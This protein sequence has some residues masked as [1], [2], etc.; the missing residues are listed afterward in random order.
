MSTP[1]ITVIGSA[2]SG[3]KGAAAMLESAVQTLGERLGEVEFTLLSMYPEEDRAQNPYPNL[4]VVAADP[5]T[6]GVTINSLALAHRLLPPLRPLLRRHRAI[7]ALA[8]SDALLDQG[9]ITFTDG[10]EKFLLYNVASILPA[11]NLHTPVF[12]CAQAVGPFKNPINRIVSKVFLPKAQTL[13]TR[14]RITHEFAEGLG[15]TNLVAGA[16]Y[17]FSLEMDGTEE[18]GLREAGVDLEFFADCEVV[19]V[20]PSV[21][22]QKKVEG[23]GDDYVG[24]MIAFIERLRRDGKKVLLVPHSVRTGTEKSHNN[25]LPLC[26]RINDLLV[27]GEDVLFVDRELSS[28]QLRHL[29]GRCD[30][31]VASRFHAMVS[32]LA[33]AV[34]TLVIGWSHKYREVLEMFALEEWAFG[35]DQLTPEHLWSRFEDL[36]ARRDEVQGKLDQHLPEVKR[37]SLAQADLIAEL[38]TERAD[39]R[40]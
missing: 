2:L 24:Q 30:L 36:S 21:V 7:R 26:T 11:L 1:R 18:Q 3:N 27:R 23:R 20:C 16:D 12:K 35:H 6:L 32:S 15:L 40:V 4:E 28:Q 22:L 39:R 13:V 17:A 37:R 9:G 5:K 10:R 14:G 31:F 25:D 19:G 34:P 8:Q 29:I 33:M 38:V